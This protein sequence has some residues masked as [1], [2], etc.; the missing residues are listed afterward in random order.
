MNV[1]LIVDDAIIAEEEA[2]CNLFVCLFFSNVS[3]RG[4]V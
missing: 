2:C 1:A 3:V 4:H